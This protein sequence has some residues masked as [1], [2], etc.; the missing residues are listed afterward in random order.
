MLNQGYDQP[1]NFSIGSQKI[2]D[3][4]S[5]AI[6]DYRDQH[7]DYEIQ[8]GEIKLANGING[9]NTFGVDERNQCRPEG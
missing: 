3:Q 2:Y 7:L 8:L 9:D 1:L 4:V 6:K 5:E